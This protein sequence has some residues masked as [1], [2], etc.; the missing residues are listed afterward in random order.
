MANEAFQILTEIYS[1][2]LILPD[3]MVLQ[4]YKV[5]SLNQSW[6]FSI[7]FGSVFYA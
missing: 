6:T 1:S 7:I 2:I 3:H 5:L 4:I